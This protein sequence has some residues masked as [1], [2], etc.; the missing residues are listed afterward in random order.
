MNPL[1]QGLNERIKQHDPHVYEMLSGLGKQLYFPRGILSQTAEAKT[2]ATRFNATIGIATEDGRPMRLGLFDAMLPTLEPEDLYPYAPP[3]GKPALREAWRE[4]LIEQNPSMRGKRFGLPIVTNA[5]T[6]GLSIVADM[7]AD[8]GDTLVLPDKYWG[9]YN[10][11]FSVRRGATVK[12]YRTFDENGRYDVAA[13]E[14]ALAELEGGKAIVL[15]NFPN[16][17]TGYTPGEE[18]AAGIVSALRQSAEAGTNLVVVLDDAYFGLFYEDSI[19]ESLFG[20]IAGLH[21]RILPI[22]VDG[23]TKEQFVWGFRVGFL[24]FAASSDETLAA[25]EAKATGCIR[26]AISSGPHPSQTLVLEALKSPEF[27]RQRDEKEAILRAR[28]TKVK[29]LLDSGKYGDAWTYYPFNS[30]YFMCLKLNG[31]DAEALRTHLLDEYGVGTI[32]IGS[33]DLRI[34][35]SCVDVADVEPLFDLIHK[36]YLDL[37]NKP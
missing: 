2:K 31:V 23:A 16:N 21:P 17:P 12:T 14:R 8:V 24:T 35:F 28:A 13:L 37:K 34:A 10:L 1:A 25:L 30:G 19:K 32:S 5:L 22:K 18:E 20:R 9:N 7:F 15:L 26:G 33:T 6:H 27:K 29:S 36:G 4:R 3:A 11:T